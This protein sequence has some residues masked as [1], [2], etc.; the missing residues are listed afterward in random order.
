M[1]VTENVSGRQ[2]IRKTEK[3]EKWTPY[4]RV[5]KLKNGSGFEGES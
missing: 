3:Y 2:E 5:Q 4:F 1:S